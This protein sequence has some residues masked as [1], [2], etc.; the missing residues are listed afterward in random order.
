MLRPL[1]PPSCLLLDCHQRRQRMLGDARKRSN[2]SKKKSPYVENKRVVQERHASTP[3]DGPRLATVR[4]VV[5][6]EPYRGFLTESALRSLIFH[7]EDRYSAAGEKL[8]GNGLAVA[9]IRVGKK[10]LIDL[11]AFDAWL[12]RQRTGSVDER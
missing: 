6:T 5:N 11:N 2:V 7:A 1:D 10:I 9:I 4:R 8:P 12:L 3:I